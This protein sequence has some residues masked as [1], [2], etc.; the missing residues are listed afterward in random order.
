M[1][2]MAYRATCNGDNPVTPAIMEKLRKAH[3]RVKVTHEDVAYSEVLSGFYC[4]ACNWELR[5]L[6]N[7]RQRGNRK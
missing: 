4:V 3:S 1:T 6:N 2:G 7:R 5:N